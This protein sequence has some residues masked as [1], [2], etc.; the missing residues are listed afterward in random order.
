MAGLAELVGF[1]A[2]CLMLGL[3]V[4]GFPVAWLI[5]RKAADWWVAPMMMALGSLVIGFVS[6]GLAIG[7]IFGAP[8]GFWWWFF[9]RRVLL[10]RAALSLE[11]QN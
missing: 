5:G 2:V 4:I 6:R 8:T 3:W 7:A 10:R 1:E 9:Y 11:G